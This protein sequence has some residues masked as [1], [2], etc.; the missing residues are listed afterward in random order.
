VSALLLAINAS[1]LTWYVFKGY[2]DYFHSDSAAKVLLANE[3]VNTKKCF[4]DYTPTD[5]VR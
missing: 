4:P 5:S 3:I 2:R 1:F